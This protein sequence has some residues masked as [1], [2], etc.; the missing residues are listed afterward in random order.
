M[1]YGAYDDEPV[2][3]AVL[4]TQLVIPPHNTAVCSGTGDTQRGQNI[5][6]LTQQGQMAWQ[7]KT[8]YNLRNYAELAMQRYQ[9]IFGSTMKARAMPQQKTEA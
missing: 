2:S 5:Q 4:G 7:R 8:A 6:T 9:R 1:G 3:Q